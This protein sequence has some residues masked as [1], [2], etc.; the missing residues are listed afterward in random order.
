[1]IGSHVA[2]GKDL[3]SCCDKAASR[4]MGAIQ[5]FLGSP[6]SPK[7]KTLGEKD[8]KLKEIPINIFSHLPYV[9][10]LAGSV[11][12]NKIAWHGDKET[13]EYIG[14]CL[15][16]I[17]YELDLLSNI[18]CSCKG[19]VL[20]IGSCKDKS[21]GLL[22]V[23]ESI[24]KL[25]FNPGDAP[26]LLETMVGNGGV[27]GNSFEDLA[28]VYNKVENKDRVGICID[29][30]HVFASGAYNLSKISE[31]DHMFT[32]FD[33]YFPHD[34]CKLIH[35]NDSQVAFGESKDRHELITQGE[36]WKEDDSSL[37]HLLRR[38]KDRN[39]PVVLE[40]SEEDFTN[41]QFI[42]KRI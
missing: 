5:V 30:C 33:N 1:M 6:Y 7:R 35:L 15:K 34:K 39:I 17:D 23:A 37:L 40:T 4:G 20:H 18:K 42:Y 14:E 19:C 10:N 11:K 38:C 9:Y 22:A 26:L 28:V 32:D 41:L 21:T 16:S 27:L 29:T 8:K 31:I 13:D 25:Q 24:N 3:T 2:I 12:N 36:I